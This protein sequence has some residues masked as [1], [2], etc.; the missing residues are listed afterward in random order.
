MNEKKNRRRESR[1]A[2]YQEIEIA[3]RCKEWKCVR[4][5]FLSRRGK[6]LLDAAIWIAERIR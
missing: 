4:Y 6:K 3:E 2:G 5:V 1:R